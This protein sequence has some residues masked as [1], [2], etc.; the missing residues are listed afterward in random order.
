MRNR[1]KA[2]G[3]ANTWS[4]LREAKLFENEHLNNTFL[5]IGIDKNAIF[6]ILNDLTVKWHVLVNNLIY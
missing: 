1:W 3:N 2:K 6:L 5:C 4:P